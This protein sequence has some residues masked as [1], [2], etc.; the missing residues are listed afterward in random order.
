MTTSTIENAVAIF[1]ANGSL[2]IPGRPFEKA[3]GQALA[4]PNLTA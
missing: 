2:L 1:R 4:D 3:S